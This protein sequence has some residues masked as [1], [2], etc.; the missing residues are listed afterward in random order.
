M[1]GKNKE[2][3]KMLEKIVA[4]QHE[5]IIDVLEELLEKKKMVNLLTNELCDLND[6][7]KGVEKVGTK[8]TKRTK[9]TK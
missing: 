5:M 8:G 2:K 4:S 9:K 6:K 7:L 1:F 3:I